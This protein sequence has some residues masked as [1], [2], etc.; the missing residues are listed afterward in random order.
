M[1]VSLRRLESPSKLLGR[2]A[3]HGPWRPDGLASSPKCWS[4]W[5]LYQR[6][7]PAGP[8]RNRRNA[9]FESPR[10]WSPGAASRHTAG[11]RLFDGPPLCPW[12]APLP[13]VV[14]VRPQP[15]CA[16]P[17]AC[18]GQTDQQSFCALWQEASVEFN[19]QNLPADQPA[20]LWTSFGHGL[21]QRRLL[22]ETL[23]HPPRGALVGSLIGPAIAL[24]G[25]CLGRF[26]PAGSPGALGTGFPSVSWL[27]RLEGPRFRPRSGCAHRRPATGRFEAVV[28]PGWPGHCGW[29]PLSCSVA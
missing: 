25:H 6:W 5:M 1:S 10:P 3:G 18:A 15:V 27:G 2:R 21:R 28:K 11:S 9:R 8:A 14:D 19:Q 7:R 23:A 13:F 16:T 24:C 20:D 4:N 22:K 26:P 29:H 17:P 12:P